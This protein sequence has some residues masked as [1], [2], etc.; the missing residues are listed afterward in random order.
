MG[1]DTI[2]STIYYLIKNPTVS[3]IAWYYVVILGDVKIR[4]LMR[5][6]R[7]VIAH[8]RQQWR[9]LK[10]INTIYKMLEEHIINIG[11]NQPTFRQ[12][13]DLNGAHT[14]FTLC[15]LNELKINSSHKFDELHKTFFN[16]EV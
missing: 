7:K 2:Y 6:G 5:P 14:D 8:E 13:L 9:S 3:M 10:L 1:T 15:N 4:F 16:I 12:Y 11:S